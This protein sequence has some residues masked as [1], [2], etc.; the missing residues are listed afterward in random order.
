VFSYHGVAVPV[1]DVSALALGR[2][3]HESLSTRLVLIRYPAAADGGSRVL[4][5]LVEKA[6]ETIAR[7]DAE[8]QD[9]GVTSPAARYL[10]PVTHDARGLIQRVE[11]EKI[12]PVAVR[13]QLFRQAEECL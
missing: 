8:F 9:A 10:G 5:L 7:Q 11:I 4:G 12:L 2:P 13:E 3:A 1:V 6:T